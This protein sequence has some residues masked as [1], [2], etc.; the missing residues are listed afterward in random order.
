M[1]RTIRQFSND[2]LKMILQIRSP[3][4]E[5]DW[6][7]SILEMNIHNNVAFDLVWCW[8]AVGTM[9]SN[10]KFCF[11]SMRFFRNRKIT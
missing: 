5:V 3:G 7:L 10:E 2:K 4:S 6:M 8:H 9:I 1:S 11:Q